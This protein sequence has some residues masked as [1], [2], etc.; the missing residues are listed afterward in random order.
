MR[1]PEAP[2]R[3]RGIV[4]LTVDPSWTRACLGATIGKAVLILGVRG[5]TLRISVHPPR[6]RACPDRAAGRRV[7]QQVQHDGAIQPEGVTQGKGL[8]EGDHRRAEGGVHD[9]LDGRARS[10]VGAGRRGHPS[11]IHQVGGNATAASPPSVLTGLTS[12]AVQDGDRKPGRARRTSLFIRLRPGR[13]GRPSA[14]ASGWLDP[15]SPRGSIGVRPPD[16]RSR[17]WRSSLRCELSTV[18]SLSGCS[19]RPVSW[20]TG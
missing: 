15:M 10:R 9:H 5:C 20:S 11:A 6:W 17:D 2:G 13:S 12:V 19:P 1:T 16:A 18:R 3:Q 4:L 7:G 8:A 14:D